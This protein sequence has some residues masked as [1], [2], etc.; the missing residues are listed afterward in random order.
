MME[1][2]ERFIPREDILSKQFS[3]SFI[4]YSAFFV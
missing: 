1:I 4:L 2:Q 3:V